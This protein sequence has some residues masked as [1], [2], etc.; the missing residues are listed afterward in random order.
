MSATG[1]ITIRPVHRTE[2]AAVLELWGMSRSPR[3]RTPDTASALGRLARH[4]PD[5]LL[6]AELDGRIVGALVAAWDGWRGNLYRLAVAP[7]ARRRGIALRLVREG[8]HRLRT[9]GA[10]RIGAIVSHEDTDATGFWSMAGYER[11][12]DVDRYVR[13]V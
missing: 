2:L 7:A 11:D 5:A 9:R 10:Q 13:S 4:D 3:A 12:A 1:E 8:E 6:V